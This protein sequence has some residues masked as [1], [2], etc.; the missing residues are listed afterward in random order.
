MRYSFQVTYSLWG[1]CY[2]LWVQDIGYSFQVSH[3][4]WMFM[5]LNYDFKTLG[6]LSRCH[7]PSEC[8][9]TQLW[10]QDIRY[11]FQVSHSLWMFMLFNYDFKSLGILS[12]CHTPSECLCY[13]TMTSRHWISNGKICGSWE[14]PS[15]WK[16]YLSQLDQKEYNLGEYWRCFLHLWSKCS[17]DTLTIWGLY[18]IRKQQLHSMSFQCVSMEWTWTQTVRTLHSWC[19]VHTYST[20]FFQEFGGWLIF[21]RCR[22]KRYQSPF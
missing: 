22:E 14:S 18:C 1:V 12:R 10:L 6:I 13:S 20:E 11:S 2:L 16:K 17:I 8:Y 3:S 21:P 7:T 19:E 5:L 9:V 15:S 4:L